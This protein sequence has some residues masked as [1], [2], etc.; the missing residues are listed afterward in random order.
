M[1]ELLEA[2]QALRPVD[3]G[4]YQEISHFYARHFQTVDSGDVAG[5]AGGFTEDG[6]FDSN[7][8][9]APVVGRDTIEAATH[10]SEAA[11]RT[12]GVQRRH[13]QTTLVAEQAG[14]EIRTRAY[15]M[16]LETLPASPTTVY[17]AT[18]CEDVLVRGADGGLLIRSRMI[19]RDDL[20]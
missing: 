12:T 1:T 10:R 16:V 17:C 3:T 7:V 11:R 13:V 14:E 6:V 5:W 2:A 18:L 9:P 19:L 20:R 8:L 4:L 15:V